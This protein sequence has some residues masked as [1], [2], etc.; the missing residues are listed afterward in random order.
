MNSHLGES[1]H[2]VK[3]MT[4]WLGVPVHVVKGYDQ[5]AG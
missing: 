5:L 4:N 3:V 1:F 2:V